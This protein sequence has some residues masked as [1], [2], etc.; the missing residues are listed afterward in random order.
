MKSRILSG[1]RSVVIV[2]SGVSAENLRGKIWTGIT[3]GLRSVVTV[4]HWR[5]V[6]NRC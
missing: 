6:R 1:E 4:K 2:S 3:V 5:V